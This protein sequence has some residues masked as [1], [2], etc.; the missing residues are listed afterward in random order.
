MRHL[1]PIPKF[2]NEMEINQRIDFEVEYK[3]TILRVGFDFKITVNF[4]LEKKEIMIECVEEHN[5]PVTW[6]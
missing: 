1:P 4:E 5:A 2:E 6:E 3:G